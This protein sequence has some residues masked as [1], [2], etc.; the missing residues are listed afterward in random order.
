[1][2]ARGY[3]YASSTYVCAFIQMFVYVYT[4]R[5]IER[6]RDVF[7]QAGEIVYIY[8]YLH[9]C[10]DITLH[11][12]KRASNRERSLSSADKHSTDGATTIQN[13][14]DQAC[15]VHMHR[16]PQNDKSRCITANLPYQLSAAYG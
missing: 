16:M 1:M 9:S 15:S 7:L 12:T 8:V 11:E 13:C 14:N 2:Q 4:E 10:I 3:V 6:E 5:E